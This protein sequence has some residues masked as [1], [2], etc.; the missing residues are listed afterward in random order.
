MNNWRIVNPQVSRILAKPEEIVIYYGTLHKDFKSLK[1]A[2]HTSDVDAI[3]F[4]SDGLYSLLG[5]GLC[6]D[7]LISSSL[8]DISNELYSWHAI[9]LLAS[10]SVS[11]QG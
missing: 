6:S 2:L 3:L 10:C 5:L 9:N 1:A 8:F 11:K 7:Q 4:A